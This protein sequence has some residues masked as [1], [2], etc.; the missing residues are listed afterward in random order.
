MQASFGHFAVNCGDA[1][2]G[3]HL[4]ADARRGLPRSAPTIAH[5]WLDAIEAVALAQHKDRR[6]IAILDSAERRLG[7]AADEEPVWPWLFRFDLP[8]LSGYR[9]AVELRLG[10]WQSAEMALAL[11]AKAHR[12]PKQRA[13]NDVEQAQA[14]AARRH[15]DQACSLA[16]A[17]L[18]TGV[19]YGSER[20][21]RAVANFRAGLGHVGRT[22]AA[23]DDRLHNVYRNDQ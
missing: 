3:L 22:A 9:A 2:Q 17:A 10:R 19:E 21:V 20:V 18:D 15:I 16:T 7:K 12:S 11:A 23:L 4:V 5:V 1:A 14:L 6:A 13:V 8:K